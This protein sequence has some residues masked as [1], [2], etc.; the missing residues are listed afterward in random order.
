MRVLIPSEKIGKYRNAIREMFPDMLV[1][2]FHISRRGILPRAQRWVIYINGRPARP[3]ELDDVR[4][5]VASNDLTKESTSYFLSQCP[6]LEWIY[7]RTTGV[8]HLIVP[9]VRKRN[10]M[11]SR[12]RLSSEAIGEYVLALILCILKQFLPHMRLQMRGESRFLPSAMLAGKKIGILGIGH[13]GRAVAQRLKSNG[14]SI[15][16]IGRA[17]IPPNTDHIESYVPFKQIH[18]A[19]PEC[20]F[21]VITLPLTDETYH[22]VDTGLFRHMKKGAWMINVG[23]GPVVDTDALINALR[24]HKISGACLD[25]VDETHAGQLR[26]L[27][28]FPNILL[29]NHSSFYYPEYNHDNLRIFLEELKRYTTGQKLQHLVDM[30]KGY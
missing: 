6:R 24:T 22:C 10:V 16:G 26:R 8:E 28:K 9:E 20:D 12:P 14:A 13:A 15:V 19:L 4:L 5:C 21:L 18:T 23:R 3:G 25:V 7:S 27:R 30:D 11:I 2:N 1:D 29:T 17:E